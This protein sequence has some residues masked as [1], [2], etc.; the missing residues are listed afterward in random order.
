MILIDMVVGEQCS[1][2]TLLAP[3]SVIPGLLF[4]HG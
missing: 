2:G 1:Q 4:V 3:A